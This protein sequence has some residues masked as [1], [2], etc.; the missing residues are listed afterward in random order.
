M[1]RRF[2]DYVG[3]GRK[4][5]QEELAALRGERQPVRGSP[6]PGPEPNEIERLIRRGIDA[7]E[8]PSQST[9]RR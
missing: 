7:D 9:G 1:K 6:E 4:E 8:L 3:I 5:V 2:L